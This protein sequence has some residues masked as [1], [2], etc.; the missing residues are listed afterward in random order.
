MNISCCKIIKAVI[1]LLLLGVMIGVI[2]TR[3]KCEN[4][5]YL[6]KK[7]NKVFNEMGEFVGEF[8]SCFNK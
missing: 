4:G 2:L 6:K 5:R 7:A 1:F 8:T 3:L